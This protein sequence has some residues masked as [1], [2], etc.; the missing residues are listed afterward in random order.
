CPRTW[1]SQ[2]PLYPS[3]FFSGLKN[4]FSGA[5]VQVSESDELNT[6]HSFILDWYP[7]GYQVKD[8]NH[9]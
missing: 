7:T 6:I 9:N 8:F 3:L 2:K 4:A 1:D 5:M